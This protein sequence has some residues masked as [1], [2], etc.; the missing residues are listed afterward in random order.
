MI[1]LSTEQIVTL[2]AATELLPSLRAGSRPHI[3]TLYRWA[4]RGIRGVRLETARLGG[5]I[6][7]SIEAIQRFTEN[8]TGDTGTKS[9]P[10][11]RTEK[12]VGRAEAEC[13]ALDV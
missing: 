5:T 11:A 2:A 4:Q 3:C 13:E 8:C 9:V 6:V 1:D 12:R 7:T 10:A